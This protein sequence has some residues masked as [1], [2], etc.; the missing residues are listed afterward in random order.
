MK[1]EP[2]IKVW[3]ASLLIALSITLCHA[4]TLSAQRSVLTENV[5]RLHVIAESNEESEQALKEQVRDSVLEYIAPLVGS[6]ESFTQAETLI[7]ENLG[8]IADAAAQA[9]EGRA[10]RVEFSP[11]AY[12]IRHTGSYALPAGEYNSLRVIIGEGAGRNWWGIIFPYLVSDTVEEA[13][14]AVKL[15]GD[16]T[17][18]LISEDGMETQYKLRILEIFDAIRAKI[19]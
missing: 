19:G 6:A 10:V 18:A 17:F 11:M 14:E 4:V 12:P 13:N 3:E 2:K 7:S 8:G 9:S 15:L 1:N 5:V 16:G